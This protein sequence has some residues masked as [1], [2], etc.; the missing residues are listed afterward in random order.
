MLSMQVAW[1]ACPFTWQ[2]DLNNLATPMISTLQIEQE[3]GV[4]GA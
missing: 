1:V 3:E 4:T 2:G